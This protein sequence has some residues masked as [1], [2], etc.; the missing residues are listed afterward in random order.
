MYLGFLLQTHYLIIQEFL[1]LLV[2]QFQLVLDKIMHCSKVTCIKFRKKYE[3]NEYGALSF[4]HNAERNG[5]ID[6]L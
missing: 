5:L 3:R 4:L 1:I 6:T 2:F